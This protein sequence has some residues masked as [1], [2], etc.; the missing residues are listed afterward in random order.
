MNKQTPYSKENEQRNNSEHSANRALPLSGEPEGAPVT[1][2]IS[3]SLSL[4]LQSVSAVLTLLNEGC[5]IPFIS[6]YR[7]ERTG[8]LD[9]VQITDI[10]ELYDRLKE[11]GKRKETILKTI[12]EQEKLTPELEAKIRACMDS[13]ELEDIYLPYKPKR[14]TRAQIAR[15]QGLEPLALAI[16]EEAQKP[17]AP[18]DLPEGGGDKLASILQK[19]QGRAKES[20][21]SRVRIGTPPLSG[22]SGGALALDI[23]AEI[24]SENQQARNT[25]RTAYQRGAVIT[26]KVIKKMKDTEEAQKFADY[27]DFSEPLR[28]CNSHR[29]LAMRRG[30]D[31]GILRVSITIDGEECISRLTRQ[32]VRG[33]G[34]CQTLVSQAV[35]DSFKRLI[36]PSI[37]NEFAALSK[38]RADEEAIKVFTENLRQLLLSPPLG[39]KRVLALDPGFANGCKIACLDEQGNLLH[40]EIIYPHPPRNQVRQATEALR[41]MISTYKI[42]AI[43]IGNGTAS[44]ESKEFVENITTETTTTTSP[45]PSPLPRREGSDYRHLLEE[46]QQF[47]DNTS[48]NFAKQ[49]DNYHN[50]NSKTQSAGHTTPLP[51]GEGSGEGPAS[52]LFIFLVSEDGA[53]IYS[54]SPV[55]REEFPD[56][57]VTTRGAISIG[58]RLMDPLAELVKIDPKSIGVGQ[59][60]HD[61][62]QSKL[63][64]SLDQTVMSCV[65]QVGVNLNTAS[66]HLLTYVSGLGPALARNI[67]DYRREHG[68]FTSRAQL[69]KVKRLGDTAYQQC[70]GFLRIPDAK[71]PLDN[72]AVHPESYH[73]VEQ[74][75]KDLKCTIKDLIG[76]KKLLAGIDFKRYLTSHPP[77]RRERGRE[78]SPNPS[79]RRGG[80]P[81]NLP[82]RGGVPIHTQ[83]GEYSTLPQHLSEVSAS[84]SPPLSGRSG[85]ALGATLRDILTELEK[86]GHDPRGEVEVFEFDKNVHTLNDLIIGM[87]LPG[88]VT[89]ITNFGAFV[90]IGVHQDGL[91]HISQLSDRFVTDPTQ[92]IRLHQHVRVRVV[93]VDMRRK[94]IALSMKNIKQ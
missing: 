3:H 20:L 26:S 10:S 42:E 56:E 72:S 12:R 88:I 68:P 45:S 91:V 41:R 92:V 47:T 69:K 40:H 76:N 59:Y 50:P 52:S 57:D 1:S 63:K 18:P 90:D 23:I 19:Y 58:R 24:I 94:R 43:A 11:L 4:P 17:T 14:R 22:R 73:I 66:L 30:E 28:R 8:G 85:G 67:I 77:L 51:L 82:E 6:R 35:E 39:Q 44:R 34:V 21:S 38:E 84:L 62:D 71:N 5:T 27:F 7:K 16:M 93:E 36:N 70:A 54:A 29:L 25:V 32:F 49:T 37:E 60:Q 46:K 2:F 81:P 83:K 33:H 15:E 89:N 53:S 48:P 61:V 75:A 87:E 9:E 64:H 86:P 78:A 80:A 74:M 31:Q 79:E 13:T 55:A 65:N